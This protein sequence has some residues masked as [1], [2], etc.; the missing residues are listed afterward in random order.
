L[1][2]SVQMVKPEEKYLHLDL[3]LEVCER[4]TILHDTLNH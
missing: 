3:I 1:V 2:I 4:L